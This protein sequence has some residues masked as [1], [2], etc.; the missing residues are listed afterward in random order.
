MAPIYDVSNFNG[1]DVF[2]SCIEMIPPHENKIE[3]G[4]A[5]ILMCLIHVRVT[6]HRT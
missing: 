5:E 3:M 2:Q 6:I 4:S 1:S